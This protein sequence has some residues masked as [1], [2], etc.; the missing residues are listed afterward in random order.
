[1]LEQIDET[2]FQIRLG[3]LSGLAVDKSQSPAMIRYK[4]A[5]TVVGEVRREYSVITQQYLEPTYWFIAW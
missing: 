3:S 5:D 1:M 2:E 4:K